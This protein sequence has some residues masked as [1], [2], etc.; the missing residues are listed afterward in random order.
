MK[1]VTFEIDEDRRG[2]LVAG[3]VTQNVR[4]M[5]LN[6]TWS[7]TFLQANWMF[8]EYYYILTYLGLKS[9]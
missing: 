1:I 3:M 8:I 6:P 2:G 7:H 9:I 5:G 4:G